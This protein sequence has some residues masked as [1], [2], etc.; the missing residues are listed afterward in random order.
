MQPTEQSYHNS[1]VNENTITPQNEVDFALLG[2]NTKF[3]SLG[4]ADNV[5]IRYYLQAEARRL[6][7]THRI[8]SCHRFR[9]PGKS[10]VDVMYSPLV[11]KAHYKNLMHCDSVWICAVCSSKITERRREEL[12]AA[13]ATTKLTP[14]LITYTL[15]HHAGDSLFSLLKAILAAFHDFKSGAGWQLMRRD[16]CMVGSIRS[17][18]T[19]HGENGWHPHI[20]DLV[21]IEAPLTDSKMEWFISQHKKRWNLMIERQGRDASWVHGVDIRAA[22]LDVT[23]Y[24]AKFGHQPV[25]T[26]WTIEQEL[27]KAPVKKGKGEDGRTPHQLLADSAAGDEI[28]GNLFIEYANSL[29][30]KKQ[31]VWSKGLRASLGLDA[32]EPTDS[33]LAEADTSPAFVLAQ[34]NKDQWDVILGN[35]ARGELLKIASLGDWAAL[36]DWLVDFGIVLDF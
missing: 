6:L 26:G 27:T 19:T 8:R 21:L 20:H 33:E 14:I 35:D 15:R 24:V 31:L 32:R 18:E 30:G 7:P 16:F 2:S 34:L 28:A 25:S 11:G 3:A 36:R 22:R 5:V 29:K 13:L 12:S 10:T 23:Q 4:A 9:V 17:L 1:P